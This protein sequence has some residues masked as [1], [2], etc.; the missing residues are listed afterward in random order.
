M[1]TTAD[2]ASPWVVMQDF[3]KNVVA[4]AGALIGLT[5]TFASQLLGRADF[6][7]R[8]S[9]Y[10][11][12]AAAVVAIASGVAAHGLIVRFLKSGAAEKVAV[13]FANLSFVALAA[14]AICFVAFGY[15]AVG[16]SSPITAVV[17]A[18]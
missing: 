12:W 5:V 7:T 18:E 6:N 15:F 14:A 16:Q 10:A 11:A 1:L 8:L 3:S 2:P 13:F 17:A 9:L 4:L